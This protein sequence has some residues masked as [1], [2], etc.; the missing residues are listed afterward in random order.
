MKYLF[1]LILFFSVASMSTAQNFKGGLIAGMATSQYDGDTYAGFHRI[2]LNAG[3]FVNLDIG[4][5]LSGQMEMKFVQKGS[6]QSPN[7]DPQHF[8]PKYDLRLNYVEIPFLIKYDFKYKLSFEGGIGI[9]YLA[10][11][12]EKVDDVTAD[13]T[14]SR[15]FH[16]FE[17]SYQVGGYYRL[18]DQLSINIRYCY[19]ILPIR[20]HAGG[21]TYGSNFGEYNNI[22]LFSFYYQ[23]NKPSDE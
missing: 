14:N 8:S 2:G 23:F 6:F 12:H 7:P 19:S 18:F 16:K 17:L 22:I 21:G 10:G 11:H 20:P 9:S 1:S 4:K 15:P 3:C 13:P 5:K